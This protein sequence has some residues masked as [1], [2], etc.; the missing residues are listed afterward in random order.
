MSAAKDL[1][2]LARQLERQGWR[3]EH[4]RGHVKLWP[5]DGGRPLVLSNSPSNNQALDHALADL[6]RLTRERPK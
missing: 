6:R 4:H 1:R 3:R 2:E 5:P